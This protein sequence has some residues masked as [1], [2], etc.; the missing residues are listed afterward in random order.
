[1]QSSQKVT[2]FLIMDETYVCCSRI[3]QGIEILILLWLTTGTMYKDLIYWY[4][5]PIRSP[6]HLLLCLTN[7]LQMIVDAPLDRYN[8]SLVRALKES[9]PELTLEDSKFHSVPSM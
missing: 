3:L 7:A 8:G 9:F 1:M 6:L 2:G 4:T 5:S